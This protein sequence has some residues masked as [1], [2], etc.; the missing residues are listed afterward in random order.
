MIHYCIHL[1]NH[2]RQSQSLLGAQRWENAMNPNWMNW[3]RGVG[4]RR[5]ERGGISGI[6]TNEV[7][8][9]QNGLFSEA[10]K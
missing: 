2:G 7:K 8:P 3:E 10:V 1:L 6:T 9:K 4:R 5:W